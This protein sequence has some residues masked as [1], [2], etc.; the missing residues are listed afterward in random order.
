MCSLCFR[1]RYIKENAVTVQKMFYGM[2]WVEFIGLAFEFAVAANLKQHGTTRTQSV[3]KA[4]KMAGPE[5]LEIFVTFKIL[6]LRTSDRT[7]VARVTGFRRPEVGRLFDLHSKIGAENGIVEEGMFII[8]ETG[9]VTVQCASRHIV[10]ISK[11]RN[12]PAE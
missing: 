6:S 1:R 5:L 11:E 12:K 7:S 3:Y 4:E 10:S 8:D 9:A 2:S